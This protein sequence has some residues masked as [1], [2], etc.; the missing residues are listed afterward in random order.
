MI[1]STADLACKIVSAML[2]DPDGPLMELCIGESERSNAERVVR[3]LLQQA[4]EDADREGENAGVDTRRCV[5]CGA[6]GIS[7]L[8]EQT[9]FSEN[10]I[11]PLCLACFR[12]DGEAK[13][14]LAYIL[15][16]SPI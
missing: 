4:M 12:K 8:D 2:D 9:L 5:N 10:G 6:S 1:A 3:T 7:R 16:R 11:G 15:R 14:P 13:Y